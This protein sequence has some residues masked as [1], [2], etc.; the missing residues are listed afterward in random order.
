MSP[1]LLVDSLQCKGKSLVVMDGFS[2][3][4]ERK[5]DQYFLLI[6]LAYNQL[7]LVE[8]L[9]LAQSELK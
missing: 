6:E 3:G 4:R 2:I 7:W 1:L 5:S 9:I 8:V